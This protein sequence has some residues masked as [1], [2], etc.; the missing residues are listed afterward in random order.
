M[1][2]GPTKGQPNF[3][4]YQQILRKTEKITK[5]DK[6]RDMRQQVMR[7]PMEATAAAERPGACEMSSL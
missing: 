5:D 7:P 6:P 4:K 3:E 2:K 1:R